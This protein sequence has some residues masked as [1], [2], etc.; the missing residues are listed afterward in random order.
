M[1]SETYVE[2]LVA[3]KSSFFIRLLKTVLITLTV[4]FFL[5]AMATT[6]SIVALIIAVVLGIGAYFAY[7]NADIEYEYLY[8]DKE[9]SVDRV[10][11]KSRRKRMVSYDVNRMEILAPIKSYRLDSYKNRTMKTVDYSSGVEQQPDKRYMMVYEGNTKIL[12]EP[13]MEMVKAIQNVAPRKVFT[14]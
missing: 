3:K 2:C 5:L 14:D 1:V 12:L 8:L 4:V 10:M 9:I 13:S 11:A 6:L 7:M